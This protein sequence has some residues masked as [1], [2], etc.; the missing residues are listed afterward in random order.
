[1]NDAVKSSIHRAQEKGDDSS[2]QV[3]HAT[4]AAMLL[5]VA[6]APPL[7]LKCPP[8]IALALPAMVVRAPPVSMLA[9]RKKPTAPS[10]PALPW[11]LQP[12][13]SLVLGS[14]LLLLLVI[15][16]LFTEELY[17]SQSRADL[18]ATIAPVLIVLKALSDFEITPREPEPVAL[19][20]VEMSWV[21][22]SL[23]EEAQR[24][25]SWAA[26]ALKTG[27]DACASVA[28]YR[29]GKTVL[30]EGTFPAS[31]GD[32]PGAAVVP[33]PLLTKLLSKVSSAPEYLPALQLLPGRIEYTYL[34]AA[35]Q[36]VLM[37]PVGGSS[38]GSTVGDDGAGGAGETLEGK[39]ALVLGCDRQRGFKQADIGWARAIASRLADVDLS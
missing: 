13:P 21:A 6:H 38:G 5:P 10:S 30:L 24:E 15:N 7:P 1:M 20:G 4:S 3:S 34:P 35:T 22:P 39:G 9:A 36:G 19:D 16:R 29:G 32:A 26:D 14:A 12:Q 27:C 2:H 28:L 31:C 17:N 23:S 25:L 11:L 18:I 8:A 33:G 37:V